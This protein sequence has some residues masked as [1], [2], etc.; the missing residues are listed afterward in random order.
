MLNQNL[1]K[2][3]LVDILKGIY[4]DSKIRNTLGLKGG[5]AAMLFYGLPRFSVDLDFDLLDPGKKEAVLQRL[6]E[7][8]PKYGRVDQ[9]QEKQYTLFFL[10]DY[11]K[12]E[13]NL[14]VEISKRPLKA[15][16]EVRSYLGIPMLVMKDGDM[17]ACKLA[18]LITR[19]RFASRDMFDL[20]FFLANHWP[21]D[22]MVLKERTGFSIARAFKEA[23][24]RIKGTKKTELLKDELLF[25]L[26]L[27]L[28]NISNR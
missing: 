22:E 16:Y 12:G 24:R 28:S 5:T 20:W 4:S 6:R 10:I 1:H 25:Q 9:S 18:A 26:K 27:F 19:K 14:K 2:V 13:R 3:V 23:Q 17:V 8:L 11:K 15:E 21:I 7:I